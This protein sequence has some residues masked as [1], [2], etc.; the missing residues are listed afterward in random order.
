MRVVQLVREREMGVEYV[1]RQSPLADSHSTNA[2]APG[3]R[4]EPGVEAAIV[5]KI[6][7]TSQFRERRP[8]P[9]V[10]RYKIVMIRNDEIRR[11]PQNLLRKN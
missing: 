7:S 9:G 5:Q 4:S 1:G 6:L 3:S 2:S 10:E 8:D 11:T